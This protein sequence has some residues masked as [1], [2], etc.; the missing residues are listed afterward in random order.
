MIKVEFFYN[1]SKDTNT[2]EIAKNLAEKYRDKIEVILIDTEKEKIPEEYGILN[3]PVV[4]IDKKKKIQLDSKENLDEIVT[5]AI[6]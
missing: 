3:P 1:G 6:F 5:K 4:I 2:P